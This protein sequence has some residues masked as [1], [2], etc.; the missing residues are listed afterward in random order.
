MIEE[1]R[2][3]AALA[4]T[5]SVQKASERLHLTQSAVSR[6][7]Q[8]L[9]DMLGAILLDRRSKPPTL[10]DAGRRVLDRSRQ[11][12]SAVDELRTVSAAGAEPDGVMRVGISHS[13]AE[14]G[15]AEPLYRIAR[16]Y[17]GLS[18]SLVGGWSV[19]LVAAIGHGQLDAAIVL[20]NPDD[21]TVAPGVEGKALGTETFLAV[22]GRGHALPP[23]AA[24]ADVASLPWVVNAEGCGV[25]ATLQRTLARAGVP[26]RVAAEVH[27]FD[28]KIALIAR[29]LGIG[30]LPQRRLARHPQRKSVRAIRLPSSLRLDL[31]ITFLR[32]PY[33][34]RQESAVAM[35]E[36][37]VAAWA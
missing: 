7:I 20:S 19:E 15:L 11:I 31:P 9:E 30:L 25:R 33:L 35:L 14:A 1:M 21:R 6:Q 36:D 32:A 29:G 37:A 34:G 3:L 10:T 17:R 4:E 27:D 18:L 26:F 8:R 16:R 22:T 2:A 24:L 5:G 28:L 13:L 12:L 23:R